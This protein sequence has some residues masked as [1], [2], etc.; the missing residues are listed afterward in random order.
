MMNPLKWLWDKYRH[1]ANSLPDPPPYDRTE[2]V[3]R[4]LEAELA[5]RGGKVLLLRKPEQMH[6]AINGNAVLDELARADR[7]SRIVPDKADSA[8]SIRGFHAAG[9]RNNT[10]HKG[11]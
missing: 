6:K 5:K 7:E 11:E 4:Q 2:R 3:K 8:R 1:K 10:Q 9:G